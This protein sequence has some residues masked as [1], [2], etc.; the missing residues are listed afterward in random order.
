LPLY[1][2]Y[3]NSNNINFSKQ[4][5]PSKASVKS[6]KEY[7]GI[8]EFFEQDDKEF[9][10]L[11]TELFAVFFRDLNISI[12]KNSTEMLK[13]IIDNFAT[14]KS[15]YFLD[16][17]ISHIKGKGD[18]RNNPDYLERNQKVKD[19]FIQLIKNLPGEWIS[20]ENIVK[21]C[22]YR[23][24]F[25]ELFDPNFAE[26]NLYFDETKKASNSYSYGQKSYIKEDLYND[27]VKAPL[28]KGLMFLFSALGI[29]DIAYNVP[30]NNVYRQKNQE[31]LSFFDELKYVRLSSLG[32]YILGLKEDFNYEI[33]NTET[34]NIELDE[35]LLL[36]K[37]S[38]NDKYKILFIESLSEK[39]S[40]NLYQVTFSSF[41]N[42]CNTK[43][44]LEN[45]IATFKNEI[46]ITLPQV[47]S[48]FFS[49]LIDNNKS[50]LKKSDI[51]VFKIDSSDL[52]LLNLFSLDDTIRKN[53]LK[54]E[55]SYVAVSQN[56]ISTVRKRLNEFGYFI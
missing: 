29:V 51:E 41:L 6:M 34:I 14:N 25:L 43:E 33:V 50:V 2:N 48:S 9:E 42:G 38:G 36:I 55:K 30:K 20:I 28:I 5:K 37:L 7:F 15:N 35:E 23:D 47:W 40:E 52:E 12:Y 18:I 13:S 53:V 31:Y 11:K 39:I 17:L 44:D 46:N 54:V 56:N 22:F 16:T 8:K 10:S 26:S 27:L 32:E 21:Y 3:V 45:K 19:A 24:L 49:K 4:D 1:S